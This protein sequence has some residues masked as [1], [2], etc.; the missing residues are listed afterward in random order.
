MNDADTSRTLA[1]YLG[2]LRRRRIYILTVLPAALLL[3][4]WI[5]YVLTPNYRASATILLEPSSIPAELVQTTV[6]DYA[7][8]QIELVQRQL[9][10]PEQL[11]A[12][13][14]EQ[15]PYPDMPELT[16]RELAQQVASDTTIERVDP[17]TLAVLKASN[18]F[19]IHY[20]NPD[21][22]RAAAI[23]QRIADLF[24]AH[25]RQSRSD[26]ASENY[27]F[28]LAQAK[29]VEKSIA[30]AE[31]R[32]AQFKNL[33]GDA[34]P[35]TQVRNVASIERLDRDLQSVES[36]I[37]TAEERHAMLSVQL[38]RLSPTLVGTAGNWRT[39]LATLQAELAEARVRYTPDHPDVKRLQ[40][41]IEA[42]AAQVATEP[43][44]A[45]TVPDNPDYLLVQSQLSAAK[46]E[47]SALR[48]TASRNRARIAGY[49]SR[50]SVAPSVEREYSELTRVRDV[51]LAQYR[52]IQAKL[53]E[54]DVAQNLESGQ[55]GSRFAQIRKPS[56]PATPY[57]PNRLGIILLG[58]ILG[59]GLTAGLAALAE[60]SDPAVLGTRS[61]R[62]ITSYPVLASIPVMVN[63]ADRRRQRS[64]WAS[65]A[66]VLTV[67][68]LLVAWTVVLN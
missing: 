25:N 50:L 49:E 61:L 59:G 46:S 20:H 44:A 38:S 22:E 56:I 35:D 27:E 47:L 53:R 48:A 19:S 24:L 52:D 58:I 1:D 64:W 13:V 29:D 16:P 51:L 57:E 39:E 36:Q 21:P 28:M 63:E 67:A 11:E 23:A 65:Y 7:D 60:A 43:E 55:M 68:V 30:D 40:R 45:A 31:Q 37:R 12:L 14:R 32:I 9:M 6:A 3:A 2:I 10:Q 42:L 4:V 33:H 15:N 18:A 5:A 66:S 41:Q 34:L 26:R 17:I 54:A 62:E 8:Q